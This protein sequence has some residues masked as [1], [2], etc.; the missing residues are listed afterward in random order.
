MQ[1]TAGLNADFHSPP[2]QRQAICDIHGEYTSFCHFRDSW[3]GCPQCREIKLAEILVREQQMERQQREQ[4]YKA[5]IGNAGIP[6]RFINRTLDSYIAESEKQKRILGHC[7]DY[8]DGFSDIAKIGRSI[9]FLGSP[10]TGKTHLSVGIALEI[11][12]DGRTSVFTTASR[13]LRSIKD[14][15]SKRSEVTESQAIAVFTTCDLLIVDEV[16]VQRGS[17]YE[18]DMLFDVINERYENL[19]PTIILSNLTTEEIRAYLGDRVF[20][21]LRENGGRAFVLDWES[22]RG[23]RD[24]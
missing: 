11:M 15:Y 5:A 14:T 23:R 12:R 13:L 22:H 2:L 10:G 20:D 3:F 9:M 4:K 17:E 8:A 1:T 18:K 19:R 21:R 16:G 24:A 6:E 7:R